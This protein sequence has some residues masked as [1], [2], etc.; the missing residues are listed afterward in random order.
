LKSKPRNRHEAG[1]KQNS[2]SHCLLHAGF[3]LGLFFTPEEE[4]FAYYFPHACFMLGL[5]FNPGDGGEM[6]LRNAG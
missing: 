2:F 3:L 6:F 1:S 5:L 4:G